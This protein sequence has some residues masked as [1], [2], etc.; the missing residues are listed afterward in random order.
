MLLLC[1]RCRWSMWSR[2]LCLKLSG[3]M[4]WRLVQTMVSR[5]LVGSPLVW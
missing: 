5:R 4:C 3:I 1:W 2:M